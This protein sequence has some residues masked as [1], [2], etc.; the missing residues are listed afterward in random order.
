MKD[1]RSSPRWAGT[2]GLVLV[3]VIL[4]L[5]CGEV[6]VRVAAMD[7]RNYVIEM[8]RYA[9]LLKRP[10][11]DPAI[12]HEHVPGT[13]ATLQGVDISINSLGMRGPE[14]AAD[15]AHRIAIIGDS[16]ALGWGV[17][18]A[19]TLRAKL[20][21]ALGPKVDV[22]NDGVGNMNLP[23][24]VA[25]WERT[26]ARL[27]VDTVILLA[28]QRAPIVQPPPTGNWLLRHSML[29]AILV[30][31]YQTVTSGAAGREEMTE[32]MRR[33][34]TEGPGAA[35]MHTAFDRLA[36]LAEKGGYRVILVAVPEMHELQD[37]RFGFMTAILQQEAEAEGWTFVDLRPVL[38]DEPAESY[39]ATEQD[40][41]P[42]GKFLE[43]AAHRLLPLLR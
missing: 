17:P 12:G 30:T 1:T 14:P 2:V 20:E 39:W 9:S 40:I 24:V 5:I 21:H 19:E 34:W 13:S 11:A 32:A 42:N 28:T 43:L 41:H 26:N 25:H 27:P 33:E 36:G 7:Q 29:C 15:A 22:V 4:A 16:V 8:W 3:G 6:L 35:E 31:Y 18:E 38:M 10:S 23:Q 37:Y